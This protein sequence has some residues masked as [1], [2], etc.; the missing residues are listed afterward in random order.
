M[1]IPIWSDRYGLA[2]W[3]ARY[4]TQALKYVNFTFMSAVP[5]KVDDILCTL[6]TEILGGQYR[7]GERLPSERDLAARFESNRGAIREV[8]K[9]LEQ[10]GIIEVN[11]G[12]VRVLPVDDA[13]LEVFGHLLELDGAR[14]PELIGQML[15]VMGA[16]FSL[17]VRSA[18]REASDEDIEEISIIIDDLY[19]SMKNG[20]EEKHHDGW[21]QL[22][23]KLNEVHQ[24]LVLKLVGN[25]L[26]TQFIGNVRRPDVKA[27]IDQ[28][29]MCH[30]LQEFRQAVACRDS[31]KA[32]MSVINHFETMKRSLQTEAGEQVQK[33][34]GSG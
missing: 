26:R 5:S 14:I 23:E 11:P 19:L 2:N 22:A 34:A 25:G 9:K 31:E 15:E 4:S 29:A 7:V 30:L 24:N 6:R 20:Q 1:V 18:I 21:R 8:I 28:G 12:G 10:L 3:R 13:T 16:M 33:V 27:E 17:S 32:G